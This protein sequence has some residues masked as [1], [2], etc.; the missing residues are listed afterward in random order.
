M[1]LALYLCIGTQ[2]HYEICSDGS[3]ILALQNKMCFCKSHMNPS[4]LLL[5]AQAYVL[6]YLMAN[7]VDEIHIVDEQLIYTSNNWGMKNV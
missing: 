5:K 7:I 6:V 2:Y 4:Q 3:T 1:Y